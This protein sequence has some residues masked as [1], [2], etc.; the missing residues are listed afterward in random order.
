M[1]AF[2]A[3]TKYKQSE[4]AAKA[5]ELLATRF[6]RRDAYPD[7]QS[8][9]FWLKF[10][11]P[12]WQTDL[13]SSLDSLSLVGFNA[14]N[15]QIKKAISWFVTKQQQNGAWKLKLISGKDKDLDLWITLAIC[16][17]FKKFHG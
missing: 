2:A 14:E 9:E 13:L 11:Y 8:V 6:F 12:F 3:H 15:P 10:S 17:V 7:R 1:R 16:R 5:G 4:E